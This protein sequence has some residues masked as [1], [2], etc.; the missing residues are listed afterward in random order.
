MSKEY[1]KPNFLFRAV[2]IFIV[3]A[4][5]IINLVLTYSTNNMKKEMEGLSE[6]LTRERLESEALRKRLATE[7]DEEAIREEAK[8]LGYVNPDDIVFEADVP[9]SK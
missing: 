5:I 9:N 3:A 7:M 8:I 1:K 4:L 2:M 6:E